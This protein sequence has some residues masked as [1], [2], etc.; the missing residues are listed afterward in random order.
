[1]CCYRAVEVVAAG[2]D[3]RREIIIIDLVVARRKSV[4]IKTIRVKKIGQ[5]LRPVNVNSLRKSKLGTNLQEPFDNFERC[6][7]MIWVSKSC[8]KSPIADTLTPYS[9]I[10]LDNEMH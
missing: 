9:G 10:N 3:R 5:F 8:H 6:K 7:T 1:M 4:D 2:Y